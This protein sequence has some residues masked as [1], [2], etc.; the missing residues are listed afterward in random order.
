MYSGSRSWAA[1]APG[2]NTRTPAGGAASKASNTAVRTLK[3]VVSTMV[4]LPSRVNGVVVAGLALVGRQHEPA[5]GG[6][7]DVVGQCGAGGDAGL[8]DAG[9]VVEGD[10]AGRLRVVVGDREGDAAVGHGDGVGVGLLEREAEGGGG[11]VG[12]VEHVDPAVGADDRAAGWR[13]RRRGSRRPTRRRCP[14]GR[15]P[16]A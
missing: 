1:V 5:R 4:M 2:P 8:E 15:R 10:G 7:R 9:G 3:S 13:R 16:G 11:R 12:Q 14:S 6:E